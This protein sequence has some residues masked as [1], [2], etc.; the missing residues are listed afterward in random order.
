MLPKKCNIALGCE[1]AGFYVLL[2]RQ[3]SPVEIA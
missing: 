3:N 1:N 2:N